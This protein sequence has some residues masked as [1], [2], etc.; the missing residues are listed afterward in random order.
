MKNVLFILSLFLLF[1]CS[2]ADDNSSVSNTVQFHAPDWI[3]GTWLLDTEFT[4]LG[5][6]FSD[7]DFCLVSLSTNIC[8][9]ESINQFLNVGGDAGINEEIIS[10]N[11]YKF[12]FTYGGTTTNYDFRKV[13][14]TTISTVSGNITSIYIKQ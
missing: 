14:N 3:H 8:Y 5:Y 12:S 13:S 10:D 1:S 6:S 2:G 7:D 4:E 11:R 9:K